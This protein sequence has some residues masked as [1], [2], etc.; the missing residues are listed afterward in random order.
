MTQELARASLKNHPGDGDVLSDDAI[1]LAARLR[2]YSGS[3]NATFLFTGAG[4][5]DRV[6]PVA[7]QV[8]QALATMDGGSVL[9]VDAN[10]YAPWLQD[11]FLA[12]AA[13][14]GEL[15]TSQDDL[16]AVVRSSALANL[17]LLPAGNWGADCRRL[18]MSKK[19]SQV[20][21]QLREEYRYVIV[22]SAPLPLHP[23]FALLASR[24]NGVALVL[25]RGKH[26]KVEVA[27]VRRLLEGLKLAFLGVVLLR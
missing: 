27:E 21:E 19:L 5:E 3:P 11:E 24:T 6:G 18:L 14:L 26:T 25:A 9:F 10:Y 22:N 4:D 12:G 15:I 7:F 20:V 23:E 1:R 13:G 8:A 2:P 16:A 17:F